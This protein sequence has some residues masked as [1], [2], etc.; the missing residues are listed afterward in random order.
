MTIDDLLRESYPEDDVSFTSQLLIRYGINE[1]LNP[2][3]KK[4]DELILS[5]KIG[6]P[7]IAKIGSIA[8]LLLTNVNSK[9]TIINNI[10]EKEKLEHIISD[11]GYTLL[12]KIVEKDPKSSV[13]T[14]ESIKEALQTSCE[15]N[16]YDF[17]ALSRLF[18]VYK[19]VELNKIGQKSSVQFI[20][21]ERPVYYN[22]NSN[23]VNLHEL[24]NVLK[25][26]NVISDK[27]QFLKLFAQPKEGLSVSFN[28][29]FHDEIAVLFA[30]LYEK[31]HISPLG[32]R[33]QYMPL[34]SYAVDFE[35][36]ILFVNNFRTLMF[37]LRKNRVKW[38]ILHS[39]A[40]SWIANFK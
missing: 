35:G 10:E 24:T 29:E 12:K 22:W 28:R 30:L 34:K 4:T 38:D 13:R 17:K 3:I 5:A 2:I 25:A 20:Y 6:E 37:G 19:Y 33:G 40:N 32:N 27:G 11:I 14:I 26:R 23:E 18:P 16:G 7:Q 36:N 15:V 31:K 8:S 21:L 39:K 9:L 1:V